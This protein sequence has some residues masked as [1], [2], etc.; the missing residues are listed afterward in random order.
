MVETEKLLIDENGAPLDRIV[1]IETEYGLGATIRDRE[2]VKS[3]E[4]TLR[5]L[6]ITAM[7]GGRSNDQYREDGDR[8]YL[9]GTHPERSI[10]EETS[11]IGAAYRVLYGHVKT[12][13]EFQKTAEKT[14]E[15]LGL[16][17]IFLGANTADHI[18]NSWASHENFLA[19]RALTPE[20]Y[21]DALAAHHVSR[22]VWSG[23]GDVQ[24][25]GDDEF[26]FCL[27]EK[28]E[29]IWD[30][31][32]FRTTRMRP[33][34]NLR[35]VPYADSKQFRRIHLVTGESV[36]SAHVI[37]LRLA[38]GSIILRA[39]EVGEDFSDLMPVNPIDAIRSISRD[40]TLKTTVRLKNEH[41]YTGIDHQM[42]IAERALS[43]AGA[44][45]YLTEQEESWGEQWLKDLDDLKTDPSKCT[46]RFDWLTK[47]QVI[48]RALDKA[49]GTD[50]ELLAVAKEAAI[51]YHSLLPEEGR[52]MQLLRRGYFEDSPSAEVLSKGLSLPE[53]RAKFRASFICWLKKNNIR[54]NGDWEKMRGGE[55]YPQAKISSPYTTDAPELETLMA[56]IGG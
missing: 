46:D 19:R 47:Q 34:V 14:A 13:S 36:F 43:A 12:A 48:T 56:I 4:M 39:C 7:N 3:F 5:L 6:A 41:S 37:A 33:L 25:I 40:P 15:Q 53:T 18:G 30:L 32:N 55:E 52:G 44:H 54:F 22:I 16:G 27:S 8:V 2:K 35:D 11:F 28:A 24:S 38:S 17:K 26:Q 10:A 45:G 31:A 29:Q 23:S 20:D 51:F 50:K 9:D 21:I 49:T 42:A 1:G